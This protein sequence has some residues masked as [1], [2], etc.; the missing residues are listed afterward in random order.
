MRRGRIISGILAMLVALAAA[1]AAAAATPRQIYADLAQHGK[2]TKQYSQAD[3]K[4]AAQDASLQG[5]GTQ[6]VL[7]IIQTTVLPRTQ[8][9]AAAQKTLAGRQTKPYTC[10]MAKA[11]VANGTASPSVKQ[12]AASCSAVAPA[13]AGTLPF[14]GLQLTLFTV[15]GL[16]LVTGGFL[17]RRTART[18]RDQA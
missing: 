12:L 13:R 2:L 7:P 15:I 11:A 16:A 9:V 1:S 6:E 3:L 8:G 14:T 4:R 17:L 18:Q 10:A 5:Y